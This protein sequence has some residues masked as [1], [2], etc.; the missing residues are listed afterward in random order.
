MKN[1]LI[2][3]VGKNCH[4]CEQAM[5]LLTPILETGDFSLRKIDIATDVSLKASYGQRIPLLLL[6]NGIEKGWPFNMIQVEK[7][8]M[9]PN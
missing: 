4:L 2:L 9:Q 7:L 8:L 5:T 6:P 3:Y 1:E